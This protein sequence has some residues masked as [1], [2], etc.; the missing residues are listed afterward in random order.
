[1]RE[2]TW[3][4]DRQKLGECQSPGMHSTRGRKQDEERCC[5]MGEGRDLWEVVSKGATAVRQ[6]GR[7]GQDGRQ[8]QGTVWSR[9]AV[10]QFVFI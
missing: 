4:N 2:G 7:L 6:K 5:L 10:D 3:K 9:A 1:M 8:L